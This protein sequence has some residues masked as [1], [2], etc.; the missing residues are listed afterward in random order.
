VLPGDG[1]IP[2]LVPETRWSCPN[3][4]ATHLTTIAEPHAPFHTCPGLKGIL[5][6]FVE[7]GTRCRVVAMTREDYINDERGL[8]YNADGTPIMSVRTERWDGSNDCSVF[9]PTAYA[10]SNDA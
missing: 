5:A 9:A 2:L 1:V 7:D 3:C 4:P 6:P 10:R 8:R